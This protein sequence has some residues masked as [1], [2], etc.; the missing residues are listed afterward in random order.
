MEPSNNPFEFDLVS[1]QEKRLFDFLVDLL[2][3]KNQTQSNI[4]L[5]NYMILAFRNAQNLTLDFDNITNSADFFPSMSN[6]E[7][8]LNNLNRLNKENSRY[9][10]REKKKY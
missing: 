9:L 6:I 7:D 10:V 2:G 5:I 1:E 3:I 4:N 8:L